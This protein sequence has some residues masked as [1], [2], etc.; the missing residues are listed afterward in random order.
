MRENKK[1]KR[2]IKRVA[3]YSTYLHCFNCE[4]E[5][6]FDSFYYNKI[7]MC[8][9]CGTKAEEE[10]EKEKKKVKQIPKKYM[11]KGS[12]ERGGMRTISP[13]GIEIRKKKLEELECPCCGDKNLRN[14]NFGD[15]GFSDAY[16]VTCDSCDWTCPTEP[17]SDCGEAIGE[18]KE[19]LE[20]FS[21][22]G[23]PEER[24]EEDLTLYF[25]PEGEWREKM[26]REREER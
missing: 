22:M 24:L 6:N 1:E 4:T 15:F 16:R 5:M 3:N 7:K 13:I 10:G 17:I 25:Y 9:C 11:T 12:S 26:K 8:P 18:F 19:W 21:L 2:C 20:A 14:A 23:K